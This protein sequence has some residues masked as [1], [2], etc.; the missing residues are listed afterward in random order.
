MRPRS[1]PACRI[2]R[3][4]RRERPTTTPGAGALPEGVSAGE[5]DDRREEQRDVSGNASQ[6]SPLRS[7]SAPLPPSRRRASPG[8]ARSPGAPGRGGS[9]QPGARPVA[10]GAAGPGLQDDDGQRRAGHSGKCDRHVGAGDGRRD[11]AD[12]EGGE[13][14]LRDPIGRQGPHRDL[15][16]C[17]RGDDRPQRRPR[18]RCGCAG[19]SRRAAGRAGTKPGRRRDR[20]RRCPPSGSTRPASARSSSSAAAHG[21]AAQQLSAPAGRS[22]SQAQRRDAHGDPAAQVHGAG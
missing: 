20:R 2:G 5:Q 14:L 13:R 7:W 6:F 21:G 18:G 1:G 19:R 16:A 9:S 10:S 15:P 4:S 22:S 11:A 3:L 17:C 12:R 8:T